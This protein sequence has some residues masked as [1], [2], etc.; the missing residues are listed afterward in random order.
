MPQETLLTAARRAVRFFNIDMNA[1]GLISTD[2]QIAIDTL[3]KM[4][5]QETKKEQTNVVEI[6]DNSRA[7]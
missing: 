1:G 2:T 6:P 5:R 7:D 3:D 4:I